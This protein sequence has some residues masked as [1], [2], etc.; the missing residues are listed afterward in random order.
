MVVRHHY[1]VVKRS[2]GQP[3]TF[4][5]FRAPEDPAFESPSPSVEHLELTPK[6]AEQIAADPDV[7]LGPDMP[8][9]L[10]QPVARDD[11]QEDV[12]PHVNDP[13]AGACAWGVV[14]TGAHKSQFTGAGV[15]VAVLDT[16]IQK[17]HPAFA[18]V[19]YVQ[20]KN[21]LTGDAAVDDDNG[22][23]T[24]CAGTIFG[25]NGSGVRIAVA[26][27][28]TEVIVGKVL[29]QKGNGSTAAVVDAILWAQQQGANV[30]SLSLGLDFPGLVARLTKVYPADIAVA[31]GLRQYREN[32]RL[33][34]SLGLH[35]AERAPLCGPTLLV[36][37]TGNESRRQH[38]PLYVVT[39]SL[40][41]EGKEFFAVGA[42]GPVNPASFAALRVAPFSNSG[43]QASAPGV[44]VYSATPGS[45]FAFKSGTSMATPHVAAVAALWFEKFAASGSPKAKRARDVAERLRTQA[46][47]APFETFDE[48]DLG[49]G[50]VQAP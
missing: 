49:A 41:A 33:F 14:A 40:P 37:A 8:V 5:G 35:V 46:I 43:P 10:I 15:R 27:G 1:V 13:T 32:T 12:L 34:D 28:V 45:G 11:G 29:D 25:R 3:G 22:H 19:R 6:E 26:P 20:T 24:H 31:L 4:R 2:G 48:N 18:H 38:N 9:R 42:V 50:L 39:A 47:K 7:C 16:G 21:F 23:G 30:V 36:V 44:G 17:D